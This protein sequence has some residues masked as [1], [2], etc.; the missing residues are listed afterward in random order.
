M[1]N[2]N[3]RMTR[4]ALAGVVLAAV[5]TMD[6]RCSTAV[7]RPTGEASAT[8]RLVTAENVFIQ[9]AGMVKAAVVQI[10]TTKMVRM[11][12]W[13]PFAGFGEFFQG[14]PLEDVFG[15]RR[16]RQQPTR[17]P[18][19]LAWTQHS[20]EAYP[21][22]TPTAPVLLRSSTA[23]YRTDSNSLLATHTASRH[24]FIAFLPPRSSDCTLS[25]RS[26]TTSGCLH[27]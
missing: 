15:H 21:D 25:P 13:S 17:C 22:L 3:R 12:P 19:R 18:M 24:V 20:Q 16:Q 9:V 7:A 26:P 27:V 14:K 8:R 11:W 23:A 5:A 10:N 6:L 4:L 1:T 2:S